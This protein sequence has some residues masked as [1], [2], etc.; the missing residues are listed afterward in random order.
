MTTRRPS[1]NGAKK[2]RDDG[3]SVSEADRRLGAS[4][5]SL[6]KAHDITL[7]DAA[8]RAGV[9]ESFLSQVER[10]IANPSIASLRR[11]AEAL[12][13]PVATLFAGGDEYDG[14]VRLHERRKMSHPSG[15]VDS[16]VTPPAAK[17]LEVHHT[18]IEPGIGSGPGLYTHVADEE[19]VL[20]LEGALV[21]TV[22]DESVRLAA[23]DSLL[24]DPRRG[25][26]FRNPLDTPATVLWIMTP[27]NGF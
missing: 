25:H 14:I 16:M 6:R 5:R 1:G 20:V 22:E 15:Y 27:G 24:L 26:R 3:A 18:V 17:Q 4:I 13:Q 2:Q 19:C 7:K 12:D 11:I 9:S 8:T 21:I 10:G 23:G